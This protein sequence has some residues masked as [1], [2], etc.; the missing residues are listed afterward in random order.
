MNHK[1]S[2]SKHVI[3]AKRDKT[4][5]SKVAQL[6]QYG[7]TGLMLFCN[8]IQVSTMQLQSKLLNLQ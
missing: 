1:N 6:A 3:G 5:G 2:K 7:L 4:R 8:Q